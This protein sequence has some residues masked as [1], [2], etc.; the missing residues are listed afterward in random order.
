MTEEIQNIAMEQHQ[1]PKSDRTNKDSPE[2][3]EQGSVNFATRRGKQSDHNQQTIRIIRLNDA[4][5]TAAASSPE[6]GENITFIIPPVV[7]PLS[8][9]TYNGDVKDMAACEPSLMLYDDVDDG[10]VSCIPADDCVMAA[11]SCEPSV[12]RQSPELNLL[13]PRGS[14]EPLLMRFSTDVVDARTKEE[15]DAWRPV[16]AAGATDIGNL[17]PQ[18]T[19]KASC[20]PSQMRM[21]TFD[22][23]DLEQKVVIDVT[24]ATNDE[25]PSHQRKSFAEVENSR[26]RVKAASAST[27]RE[28]RLAHESASEPDHDENLLKTR[29]MPV[30]CERNTEPS[31]NTEDNTDNSPQKEE[32]GKPQQRP[33]RIKDV[34]GRA[35]DRIVGILDVPLILIF[36]IVLY[37]VDIGSDIVAAVVYFQEGHRVWGSLTISIVVLS[38]LSWA[39]V[40]WAWWY[41]DQD[42]DRRQTYRRTRMLLSI[43]LLDP[44]VR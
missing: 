38:A 18:F 32:S 26:F 2:G 16:S 31:K 25:F 40:S 23:E 8:P 41:Y 12:M 17:R 9:R 7:R 34:I 20:D 35:V 30:L 39:A 29:S 21:P 15:A 10:N 24:Y 28:E 11:A 36:G 44:L 43:L 42:K 13:V 6:F 33:T 4:D 1:V 19:L 5:T 27:L 14:C 3:T 22:V 37:L